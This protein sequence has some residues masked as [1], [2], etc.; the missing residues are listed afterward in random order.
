M[1]T[2]LGVTLL[3]Y[4]WWNTRFLQHQGRY[5]FPALIPIAIGGAIGIQHMLES[6]RRDALI[7]LGAGGVYIA[8]AGLI[9]DNMPRY[10]IAL[11]LTVACALALGRWS[12]SRRPGVALAL[13]CLALAGFAALCLYAYIVP[14]LRPL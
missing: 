2:W 8:W 10:S 12:E 9:R 7:S 6:S 4:L 13:L 14:G 1:G 11:L 5:L 3:G